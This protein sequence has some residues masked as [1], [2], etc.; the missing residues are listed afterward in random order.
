MQEHE[1]D[2][3]LGRNEISLD[4]LTSDAILRHQAWKT[5]V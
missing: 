5:L 2:I 3:Y 1:E 4:R